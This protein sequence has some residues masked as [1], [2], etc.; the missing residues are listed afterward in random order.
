MSKPCVGCGWCCLTDPCMESHRKYGYMRRCP[1]LFWDEEKQRYMC[2][3]MLDPD[4][5][6]AEQAKNPN[7]LARDVTRPS[8]PGA[9]MSV[10][11]TTTNRTTNSPRHPIWTIKNHGKNGQNM[12]FITPFP[13]RD[14]NDNMRR[15]KKHSVALPNAGHGQKEDPHGG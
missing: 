2:G 8:T 7:T 4:P 12:A 3:M 1:D 13:L 14:D 11:E 15:S 9:M 10:I 6:T 5:E